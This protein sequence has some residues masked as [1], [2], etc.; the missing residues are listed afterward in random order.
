MISAARAGEQMK[1]KV[2]GRESGVSVRSQGDIRILGVRYWKLGG[3][4]KYACD[5]MDCGENARTQG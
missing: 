5:E 4:D 1:C 2:V 3:V